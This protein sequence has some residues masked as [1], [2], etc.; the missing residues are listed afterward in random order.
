MPIHA[1]EEPLFTKAKENTAEQIQIYSSDD[2]FFPD[3]RGIVHI[4]LVP[5]GQTVNQVYYKEVSTNLHERVS[6]RRPEMWK[7]S[8]W[9]LNQDNAPAH[10]ALAV[11]TFLTKH[12]ITVLEHPLYSPG[13]SPCDFFLFPEIKSALR[14]TR[15]ESIDT[16]KAK[17]TELM[18]KLSEDGLQ[19][20]F[21]QWKIHMEWCRDRG[22]EYIEGGAISIV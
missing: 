19:H 13:L 6:R 14:G 20:C 17:G 1:P 10:N 16:V 9:V 7:N 18:N 12:K 2:R 11:K 15:F 22:G 4:D 5:E 3:I 8:S 21:Q